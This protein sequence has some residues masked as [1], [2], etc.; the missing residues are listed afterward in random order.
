[1]GG[2]RM[3]VPDDPFRGDDGWPPRSEAGL[4][5]GRTRRE[6][7]AAYADAVRAV[8]GRSGPEDAP[9]APKPQRKKLGF[10]RHRLF[11]RGKIVEEIEPDKYRINFPGFGLKVILAAYVTLED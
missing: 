8:L 6:A 3:P 4:P 2:S 7:D 5:G 9:F 1:F 10:C 11:G